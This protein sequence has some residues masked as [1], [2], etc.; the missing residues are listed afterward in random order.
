MRAVVTG[1]IGGV[2]DTFGKSLKYATCFGKFT[3]IS[4]LGPDRTWR[5]SEENIQL[6]V[7]PRNSDSRTFL[8]LYLRSILVSYNNVSSN[9]GLYNWNE[10]I[11]KRWV[12]I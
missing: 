12:D 9:D 2:V 1:G 10:F 6:E 7:V 5:G 11:F 4:S 3:A 8:S